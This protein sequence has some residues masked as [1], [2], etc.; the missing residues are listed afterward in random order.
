MCRHR[1]KSQDW[2]R[3]G[4]SSPC[5][6]GALQAVL[7]GWQ[8]LSEPRGGTENT[9]LTVSLGAGPPDLGHKQL[10]G[11]WTNSL[12]SNAEHRLLLGCACSPAHTG[13]STPVTS[14][15]N[16]HL[17]RGKTRLRGRRLFRPALIPQRPKVSTSRGGES[18]LFTL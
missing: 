1:L 13:A 3:T 17:Y 10:L 16:R 8:R 7:T 15:S 6:C 12:L 2:Q 14:F 4:E 9:K 11:S 5:P 18:T